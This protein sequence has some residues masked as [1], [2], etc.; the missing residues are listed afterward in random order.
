MIDVNFLKTTIDDLSRAQSSSY[1]SSVDFAQEQR[2]AQDLLMTYHL[3]RFDKLDWES[4]EPFIDTSPIY[5]AIKAFPIPDDLRKVLT[6]NVVTI[7]SGKE[8]EIPA[9]YLP[10]N[11]VGQSSKS[12]LRNDKAGSRYYYRL[13]GG[14]KVDANRIKLRYLKKPPDAVWGST[15]DPVEVVETYN[16]STSTNFLWHEKDFRLLCDCFLYY[17]G[18][19]TEN[20]DIFN[21][22]TF[23]NTI[24]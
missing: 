7:K 21:S 1:T 12:T 16:P 9:L 8:L 24:V 11:A 23:K 5:S 6:I 13:E 19:R 17:R 2:L 15:I 10:N 3:H 22:I 14:I 20:Q 4:M 18:I